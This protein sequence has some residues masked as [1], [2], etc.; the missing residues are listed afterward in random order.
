MENIFEQAMASV[1]SS[2]IEYFFSGGQWRGKEYWLVSPLRSDDTRDTNFSISS[3]GFYFDLATGDKGNLIMLLSVVQ[4]TSRLEA[5]KAILSSAGKE[6]PDGKHPTTH[7]KPKE[8]TSLFYLPIPKVKRDIFQKLV[9]NKLDKYTIDTQFKRTATYPYYNANHELLFISVRLERDKE[10]RILP[11]AMKRKGKNDE[12]VWKNPLNDNRPL[13]HLP[14][15]IERPDLPVLLVEGEKCADIP[16]AGYVVATW[17]GGVNGIKK[18]DFSILQQRNVI[19]WCDND[20]V[21]YQAG[22]AI[23]SILPH[24][25]VMRKVTNKPKGWDLA[26]AVAEDSTF[27]VHAFITEQIKQLPVALSTNS[28][29]ACNFIPLGYQDQEWVFYLRRTKRLYYLKNTGITGQHL[30]QLEDLSWWHAHDFMSERGSFRLT[31]VIDY[32][33]KAIESQGIFDYPANMGMG[34]Y[35]Y[36]DDFLWHTGSELFN[37]AGDRFSLEALLPK[38]IFIAEKSTS[39]PFYPYSQAPISPSNHYIITQYFYARSWAF[40][41]GDFSAKIALGWALWSPF[42]G[43]F[44]WRPHLH[45]TAA[46]GTGKSTF[47]DYCISPLVAP[48]A[49]RYNNLTT[50]AAIRQAVNKKPRPVILEEFEANGK[51]GDRSNTNIDAIYD[52]AKS[53][54]DDVSAKTM[55][56]TP[57]VDS[58]GRQ[59][60]REFEMK[61][62]FLFVSIREAVLDAALSQRIINIEL[63][64]A[65]ILDG[66]YLD[67]E[68]QAIQMLGHESK[69]ILAHNFRNLPYLIE[70]STALT[71]AFIALGMG[72]RQAQNYAPLLTFSHFFTHGNSLSVLNDAPYYCEIITQFH[73]HLSSE[74]QM[75]D[76]EKCLDKILQAD[77]ISEN[78]DRMSATKII[79]TML[80]TLKKNDGKTHDDTYQSQA[81]HLGRLGLALLPNRVKKIKE[82]YNHLEIAIHV[83]SDPI[84]HALKNSSYASSYSSIL[85]RHPHCVKHNWRSNNNNLKYI[86]GIKPH[87]IVLKLE[88]ILPW[89]EEE[90]SNG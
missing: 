47:I 6:I 65:P 55:K 69:V 89:N 3:N 13:Y 51:D 71:K 45:L 68:S 82:E 26:D 31:H 15:I 53:A 39:H 25:K 84:R 7:T 67:L 61:I 49:L 24:A 16:V 41:K 19:I 72:H 1:T 46:A 56:G 27:D 76:A 79:R 34:F 85:K 40:D 80:V 54:S 77:I 20:E 64:K 58:N 29:H 62:S 73:Q 30:L 87:F 60:P 81:S 90:E 14:H 44:S 9:K 17:I 8:D 48:Y 50:S 22:Q 66:P 57:S 28:T 43:F 23:K 10:K 70:Q 78:N 36:E 88:P 11:I 18:S 2:T 59:S 37:T 86:A 33:K 63:A 5:A 74:K 35:H 83:N 21:G 42:C 32:L 75:S 52:L 38:K 12:V 4:G